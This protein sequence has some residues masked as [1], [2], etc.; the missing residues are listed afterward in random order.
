MDLY[1]LS[2]DLYL[3]NNYIFLKL[4]KNKEFEK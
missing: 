2:L 3:A 1:N 4:Q